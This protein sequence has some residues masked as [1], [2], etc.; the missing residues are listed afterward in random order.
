MVGPARAGRRFSRTKAK[1]LFTER[2]LAV[3]M[4]GIEYR[5]GKEWIDEIPQAYKDIDRVMADAEPLVDI[6]TSLRQIMNVKGQ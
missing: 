4:V 5:H 1:Q 2:D 6:V 3:A